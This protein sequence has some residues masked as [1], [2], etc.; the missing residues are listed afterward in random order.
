MR[1]QEEYNFLKFQSFENIIHFRR[2]VTEC[3]L[4]TDLA[5]SMNWLSNARLS[6]INNSS[7][8]SSSS[9]SS[10]IVD[11]KKLLENK[12][13]RMQLTMKCGDVGHPSRPLELHLEW[14]KRICEEFYSQGD[15]ER[16]RGMKISPLCD[17]N[18]P[19]SSYPQGQI[20][21]INFVSK[22]VFSLLSALCHSVSGE[23]KPWL[24]CMDNNLNYWKNCI[25]EF[26][27]YNEEQV[28]SE[29][30]MGVENSD[31][32]ISSHVSDNKKFKEKLIF[33]INAK[34]EKSAENK[35]TKSTSLL[36]NLCFV[37]NNVLFFHPVL[38]SLYLYI[39]RIIF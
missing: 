27:E 17:R 37:S 39:D 24:A 8:E 14:S 36:M 22:P 30:R 19:A 26:E 33:D 4:A 38:T 15:I 21:F 6:L 29:T 32:V 9:T 20:G 16:A 28:A 18:V 11:E 10:I 12:I 5:K 13:L 1:N 34:S 31:I 25:V 2:I 35:I 7:G 3:V 23:D